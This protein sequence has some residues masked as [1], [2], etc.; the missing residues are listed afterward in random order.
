MPE[1]PKPVEVAVPTQQRS[2][3]HRR[4]QNSK[5]TEQSAARQIERLMTG[6]ELRSGT[7]FSFTLPLDQALKL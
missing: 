6:Q 7:T 5:N 1:L 3:C 2:L 4:L